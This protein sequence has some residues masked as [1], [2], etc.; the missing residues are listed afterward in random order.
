MRY[1][2]QCKSKILG[3]VG[4]DGGFTATIA[5][6]CVIIPSFDL[7]TITPQV[8]AF[9]GIILHVI[10]THPLLKLNDTKWESTK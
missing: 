8:E 1:A 7:K 4:R 2:K 3:I 6:N 9:H 5:D 10:V